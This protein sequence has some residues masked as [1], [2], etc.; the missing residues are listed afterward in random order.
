MRLRIL[1]AFVG[2]LVLTQA[3]VLT[4]TRHSGQKI[5]DNSHRK[6]LKLG[7]QA[8][9]DFLKLKRQ[10]MVKQARLLTGDYA[11]KEAFSTRDQKTID[12]AIRNHQKRINAPYMGIANTEGE[13]VFEITKKD[14]DDISLA[15]SEYV[16]NS[17]AQNETADITVINGQLFQMIAVP[18][19]A[20]ITMAWV[21]IGFRIDDVLSNEFYKFAG[22]KITFWGQDGK[23]WVPLSGNTRSLASVGTQK[24]MINGEYIEIN[25][26]GQKELAIAHSLKTSDLKPIY[27]LLSQGATK[28]SQPLEALQ[29][30][31]GFF[32]LF[33]IT[34]FTALSVWMARSITEPIRKLKNT[35]N[36]IANG[37]LEEKIE[38]TGQDE[39][40]ALAGAFR[41][42]TENLKNQIHQ[43]KAAYDQLESSH[44]KEKRL[45]NELDRKLFETSTLLDISRA[46]GKNIDPEEVLY[47]I[48]EK[49]MNRFSVL[50]GSIF[51]ADEVQKK[52]RCHVVL[53]RA[54][55]GYCER[56]VPL[57]SF[58]MALDEGIAGQVYKT[59]LAQWSE[60]TSKDQNFKKMGDQDNERDGL[61]CIPLIIKGKAL[62]VINL[63]FP[64]NTSTFQKQDV[65][66]FDTIAANIAMIIDNENLFVA[67]ITDGMTGLYNNKHFRH[68]MNRQVDH[69][70]ET[71]DAFSLILF[72]IDHFKKFNDT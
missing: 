50:R 2:A 9:T 19:K 13:L 45:N 48:I 37:K 63:S 71:E 34:L 44:E 14:K 53:K 17:L 69:Y 23:R 30:R 35:A 24:E 58:S 29:G 32:F 56:L 7:Q 46:V 21:I 55:S 26:N 41:T 8:F 27:A 40:G 28:P 65:P 64:K 22:L 20:P 15:G 52:F 47:T 36:A 10:S 62:G 31:L 33:S 72:D 60:D 70:R 16:E 6:E 57:N 5:G 51:L 59:G 38:V 25:Q 43:T 66:F 67:S 18:L 68:M 1:I 61:M 12:S 42:M 39:V 11:L 54:S 4:L 49:V 3:L